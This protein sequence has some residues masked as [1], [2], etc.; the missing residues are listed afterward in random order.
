MARWREVAVK[1]PILG[2]DD[3]TERLREDGFQEKLSEWTEDFQG[4]RDELVRGLVV[5]AEKL[6]IDGKDITLVAARDFV[7]DY[8]GLREEVFAA[9]IAAGALG[10]AS[11]KD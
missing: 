7:I 8:E 5:G 10:E 6:T 2:T 11:G 4:F 1:S 3:L 9:I